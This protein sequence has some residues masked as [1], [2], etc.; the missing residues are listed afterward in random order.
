MGADLGLVT[1][2]RWCGKL[3]AGD[4]KV[5][6]GMGAGRCSEAGDPDAAP[7]PPNLHLRSRTDT[8]ASFDGRSGMV[9][10][11]WETE[12]VLTA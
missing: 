3:A 1:G 12:N 11:T 9:L 6:S 5:G 8:R 2:V 4:E 7:A 10:N